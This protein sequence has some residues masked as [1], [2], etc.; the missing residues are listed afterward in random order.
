MKKY[1][2]N[3]LLKNNKILKK[4]VPKGCKKTIISKKKTKKLKWFLQKTQ[5]NHLLK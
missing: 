2:K 3:N 4:S 5:V 1:N